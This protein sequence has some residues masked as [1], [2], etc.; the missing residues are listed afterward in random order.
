MYIQLGW[1]NTVSSELQFPSHK[2][3]RLWLQAIPRHGKAVCYPAV[4]CFPRTSNDFEIQPWFGLYETSVPALASPPLRTLEFHYKTKHKT[5]NTK[6]PK[7]TTHQSSHCAMSGNM[8]LWVCTLDLL[9]HI[10]TFL[11]SFSS[12][13]HQL[14]ANQSPMKMEVVV[15]LKF[16]SLSLS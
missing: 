7:N 5:N 1:S 10:G 13:S 16:L 11:S 15:H 9:K 3:W 12:R 8:C 6:Q 14:I 4:T 2:D